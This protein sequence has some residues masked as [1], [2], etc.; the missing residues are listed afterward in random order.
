MR[1]AA[2]R[3]RCPFVGDRGRTMIRR[4]YHMR[5]SAAATQPALPGDGDGRRPSGSGRPAAPRG[6]DGLGRDGESLRCRQRGAA[7]HRA[8]RL[9]GTSRGAQREGR[10]TGS[11]RVSDSTVGRTGGLP[12]GSVGPDGPVGETFGREGGGVGDPRR[13][14][15]DTSVASS[16]GKTRR[17]PRRGSAAGDVSDPVRT[18]SGASEVPGPV[19]CRSRLCRRSV[20]PVRTGPL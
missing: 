18:P 1:A 20:G 5:K 16:P 12:V 15:G 13:T 4:N 2:P 10:A 14:D 17:P 19:R 8:D 6:P 7:R 9:T 3:L 11:G